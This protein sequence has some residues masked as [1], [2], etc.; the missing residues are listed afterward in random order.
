[1]RT[2]LLIFLCVIVIGG[3]LLIAVLSL[4]SGTGETQKKGLEQAFGEFLSSQ[5]SFQKLNRFNIIPQLTI[6]ISGLN[7][8]PNVGSGLLSADRV[9][10]SFNASDLLFKKGRLLDFTIENLNIAS[11][12]FSN[13][14]AQ[15]EYIKIFPESGNIKAHMGAIGSY[16]PVPVTF[17]VDV[18]HSQNAMP[19]Y[20]FEDHNPLKFTM[21]KSEIVGDFAPFDANKMVFKN[22]RL[23][24]GNEKCDLPAEN[25]LSWE[26]FRDQILPKLTETEMKNQKI[27]IVCQTLKSYAL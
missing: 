18:G 11:T 27:D 2:F 14:P 15:Y 23:T 19:T 10:F 12:T 1:M 20:Y 7:A 6:D 22:L 3:L 25:R 13:Y 24:R 9:A 16:G 17:S 8:T 26:N 4:I 5:V 21:G